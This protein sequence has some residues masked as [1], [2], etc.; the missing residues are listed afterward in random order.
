MIVEEIYEDRYNLAL[1][2]EAASD[3]LLITFNHMGKPGR[4]SF[5]GQDSAKKLGISCLGIVPK[6]AH[7]Y[8]DHAMQLMLPSLLAI[9]SRYKEIITY[10]FSMGA[11]ASLKYSRKLNANKALAF[12]PQSSIDPELV[13]E[14]DTRFVS[15]YK[16]NWHK[17]MKIKSTDL[18]DNSFIFLDPEFIE[19]L[20]QA[21]LIQM[22]KSIQEIYVPKSGHKTIDVVANTLR[23][24]DLLDTVRMDSSIAHSLL[25]K[26][27][28]E[29]SDIDSLKK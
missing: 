9:T 25:Q 8:P 23:L 15:F 1:F 26:R 2:Q 18:I 17:G 7:W 12:S 5:W 10:G 14:F 29:W 24:G 6:E 27:L 22:E 3:Y 13:N 16:E 11:Y 21:K 28:Y 4:R 20:K 19:D